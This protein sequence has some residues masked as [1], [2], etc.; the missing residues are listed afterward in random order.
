MNRGELPTN[1]HLTVIRVHSTMHLMHP[2]YCQI[3]IIIL[4]VYN[5]SVRT[6][7][8]VL[9]TSQVY[10]YYI[11]M[12]IVYLYHPTSLVANLGTRLTDARC[13]DKMTLPLGCYTVLHKPC[14]HMAAT[15]MHARQ[16]Y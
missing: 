15:W 5:V 7:L 4:Q 2:N 8:G 14:Q 3:T 12:Y 13:V 9:C 6:Q 10:N 16:R 11:C 1:S